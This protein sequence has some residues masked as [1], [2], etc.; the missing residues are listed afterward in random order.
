MIMDANAHS[1]KLFI[2]DARPS[3]NAL[4]NKVCFAVFLLIKDFFCLPKFANFLVEK[5]DISHLTCLEIP[6]I[7]FK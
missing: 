1:N 5:V 2:M 3:V 6:Y 7:A 4:A